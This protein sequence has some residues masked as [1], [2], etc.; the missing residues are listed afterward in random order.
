MRPRTLSRHSLL[1]VV[2]ICAVCFLGTL[3]FAFY[4]DFG[5]GVALTAGAIVAS[6]AAG[7]I[8]AVGELRCID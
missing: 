4:L 7:I 2:V 1:L 8:R 3:G 5:L 6:C